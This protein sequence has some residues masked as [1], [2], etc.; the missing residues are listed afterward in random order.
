MKRA[1]T[2][3]LSLPKVLLILLAIVISGMYSM[4]GNHQLLSSILCAFLLLGFGE[5]LILTLA[6]KILQ[7]FGSNEFKGR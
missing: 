6:Y 4:A 7:W 5:R 3:N 1:T 2:Q